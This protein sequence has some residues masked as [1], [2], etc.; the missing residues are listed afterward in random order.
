MAKVVVL[1]RLNKNGKFAEAIYRNNIVTKKKLE[2]EIRRLST[3]NH[4]IQRHLEYTKITFCTNTKNKY[5]RWSNLAEKRLS[6]HNASESNKS[7]EKRRDSPVLRS[8][9]NRPK[10]LMDIYAIP[11]INEDSE[12]VEFN[13][14]AA[15]STNN[16][17]ESEIFH[18]SLQA[19]QPN[20]LILAPL[21]HTP[22][23]RKVQAAK[24]NS[25]S[26]K[27]QPISIQINIEETETTPIYTDKKLL[28]R[29]NEFDDQTHLRIPSVNM[30]DIP[31]CMSSPTF[32]MNSSLFD[33]SSLK[34]SSMKAKKKLFFQ[35]PS[36]LD[37]T[38]HSQNYKI[39]DDFNQ[40]SNYFTKKNANGNIKLQNLVIKEQ[41]SKAGQNP[42]GMLQANQNNLPNYF[43]R[44][45]R[46][47][48]NK[49]PPFRKSSGAESLL[50]QTGNYDKR[51][52]NLMYTLGNIKQ[53]QKS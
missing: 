24:V 7:A 11:P 28:Q 35:L 36:F 53:H 29:T 22:K 25:P 5:E 20:K 39:D 19:V 23:I 34:S 38:V 45:S 17:L 4:R 9:Y 6:R 18:N 33:T 49:N 51:F 16:F 48:R 52:L 47:S 44:Q 1:N 10:A 37:S 3:N 12:Q 46:L 15:E 26:A 27:A 41:S 30:N 42:N 32:S 43:S 8:A 21:V 2:D 50:T 31:S 13:L 40:K 14:Q